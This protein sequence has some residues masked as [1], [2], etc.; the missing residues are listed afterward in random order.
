MARVADAISAYR[1]ALQ[2]EPGYAEAHNNLGT[3]PSLN[4]A[5]FW[6]R[7]R[8]SRSRSKRTPDSRTLKKIWNRRS[9]SRSIPN[10]AARRL[11]RL[12]EVQV[13]T[14]VRGIESAKNRTNAI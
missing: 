5:D 13:M 2:I 12:L 11:A 14:Q 6:T 7:L 10:H 8:S 4:R 1:A 3:A 9:I